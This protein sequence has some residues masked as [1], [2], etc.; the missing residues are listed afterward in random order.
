[1]NKIIQDLI[2]LQK[3]DLRIGILETF[4]NSSPGLKA[5]L[6]A[7]RAAEEG[8]MAAK[9][10]ELDTAK[11]DLRRKERDLETGE[12]RLKQLLV[13]L[14]QVK[15]N[16]EYDASLRE[17][18]EQKRLN[19]KIEDDLLL[20]YEKIEAAEAA[21]KKLDAEWKGRLGEFEERTKELEQ[22]ADRAEK[23]LEQKRRQRAALTAEVNADLLKRYEQI[24]A[25]TG[26]G[27]ARVEAEICRGCFHHI[28]AQ[29]YNEVLKG[30]QVLT[31]TNCFRILVYTE[32]DLDAG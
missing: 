3:G 18:E 6:A 11:K 23:D 9:A 1:M 14:N 12:D 31:C 8:K 28:S 24:R 19:G 21:V 20:L 2:E 7:E 26:R 4:L 30:E 27:L 13:K 5:E 29:M 25:K 32:K 16:K 22:K 10:E 17:I 15:T